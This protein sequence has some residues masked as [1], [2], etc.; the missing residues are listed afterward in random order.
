MGIQKKQIGLLLLPLLVIMMLIIGMNNVNVEVDVSYDN[1]TGLAYAEE[2][3]DNVTPFVDVA[4]TMGEP[5]GYFEPL[6]NE[7]ANTTH[8]LE[9]QII[10]WYYSEDETP[11]P[12]PAIPEF[13]TMLLPMLMVL[14]VVKTIK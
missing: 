11:A 12:T 7:T 8:P 9:G 13:T 6:T 1:D 2:P 3:P 5:N 14:G 10:K 4:L